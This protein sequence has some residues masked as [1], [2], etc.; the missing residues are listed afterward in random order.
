MKVLRSQTTR[1]AYQIQLDDDEFMVVEL[2]N[3]F[4]PDDKVP[5]L[6]KG[7]KREHN[8][9]PWRSSQA[10]AYFEERLQ[11]AD[12]RIHHQ[13]DEDI[14]ETSM[15]KNGEPVVKAKYSIVDFKKNFQRLKE[16][17]SW[18]KAVSMEDNLAFEGEIKLY[19]RPERDFH[20]NPY[21]AGSVIRSRLI[22]DVKSGVAGKERL[23]MDILGSREEYQPF[24]GVP[25]T[26][27]N[28]LY[29]ERRKETEHVGWQVRRNK[30]G[31]KQH[32]QDHDI[33]TNKS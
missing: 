18:K 24:Q 7:D 27:R 12:D 21:Y 16:K 5:P 17:S 15:F 6:K 2:N 11:D 3:L 23:P 20:G 25:K 10:K 14:Y 28:Y 30:K 26:F 33:A 13:T 29:R 9:S 31:Y 1:N 19:P 8:V 32:E 4:H 22:A